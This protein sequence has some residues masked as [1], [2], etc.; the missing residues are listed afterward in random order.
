M[1]NNYVS[2]LICESFK[3]CLQICWG[4]PIIRPR[5]VQVVPAV[6]KN[7]IALLYFK[8]LEGLKITRNTI[9]QQRVTVTKV[10]Q[11][12]SINFL[13]RTSLPE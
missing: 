8:N 5:F 6:I 12:T 10:T 7:H 9:K 4:Y 11:R 2:I 13:F 3:L 1:G